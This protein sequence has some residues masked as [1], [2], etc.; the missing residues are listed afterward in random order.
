MRVRSTNQF[1]SGVYVVYLLIS[2]TFFGNDSKARKH[3]VSLPCI[4]LI[5]CSDSFSSRTN[6]VQ[7]QFR[8]FSFLLNRINHR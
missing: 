7:E 2:T 3:S 5:V 8:S 4:A 6:K 1:D